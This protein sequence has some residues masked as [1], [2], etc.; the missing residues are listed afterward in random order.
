M[1]SIVPNNINS[2]KEHLMT[3]NL[4]WI[5]KYRPSN[6]HNVKLDEHIKVQ[7]E[8]MII[9]REIPC[10]I[11]EGPP[12]VGK[13][14]TIRCIAR[15][16]YNKYYKYMV[17]ELNASDDRGIKI[18]ES[19]ENF[20]KSY[21]HI[22]DNDKKNT[23]CFKMVILDEADNM[24]DK[25][26]HIISGFI[27]NCVN[28]LRFAFT[29]NTKD[30]IISSIQSGC[31]II[32]Y[33][34]LSDE[35]IICRLRE[36]CKNE[37]IIKN[38]MKKKEIESIEKG[39][40][41]IAQITNGDMR[42]AINILQLTYNRFSRISADC[43]FSIYGK[44]HP[45]K[46]KD[47]ILLCCQK[48]MGKAIEHVLE[49]RREG[50]SGTDITMGLRLSLRLDICNDIPDNIKIEFWKCLSY[51]SYNISKGLDSSILQISACIADMCKCGKS[52]PD[53]TG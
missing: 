28:D 42:Y 15:G 9:H 13:T 37:N 7:I 25:A 38:K 21:V 17:L 30:N 48:K 44:P 31:H 11:L 3:D 40:L 6:M 20:R 26:K 8:K 5:E 18:Q 35:I 16:I 45:Q 33:P 53:K 22:A 34:P 36:I 47:I 23:P 12:G 51:S 43:V 32:K 2:K 27:K 50:Y 41:S 29:C 39:I 14:S 24:T 49:L 46:S 52:I 19:I 1:I 4:P 10:I